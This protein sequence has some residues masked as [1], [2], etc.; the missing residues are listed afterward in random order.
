MNKHLAVVTIASLLALSTVGCSG[1]SGSSENTTAPA[2]NAN[3]DSGSNANSSTSSNADANASSNSNANAEATD[4]SSGNN[5]GSDNAAATGPT[6]DK[7]PKLD[8]PNLTLVYYMSPEQYAQT[9]KENPDYFDNTMETI[10]EFE[11]KYGGKVQVIAT[12]WGGMLEKTTAMQNAGTAPDLF[13]VSDQTFHNTVTKNIVQPVDDVTTDEDYAFWKV[14]KSVFAWKGK[15][16]AIPI[17]PY[18]KYILYNKTMFEDNG[19]KTPKEYYQEG[20]WNF[21]SFAEVGKE[22]TQDTT[23]S[24]K[25][26]QWG[27]STYQDFIPAIMVENGGSFLKVTDQ[28]V[29]SGLSDPATQEAMKYL[30]DWTKQPGG[31]INFS[32]NVYDAF[33]SGK[34]AM[35]VGPEYP[36]PSLSFDVD[37]VP[38]PVGPSNKDQ[39]EFVYPQGWS[40]P[41]GSKNPQGAAAFVYMLNQLTKDKGEKLELKRFGQENYDM[42]NDPDMKITYS[43]DKGLSNIWFLIGS[44]A[45]LMHDQVPPA[46]IAEKINPQIN[47][48]IEKVYGKQQ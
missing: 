11:K 41:T 17:K 21:D 37:M 43:I 32:L 2:A 42:I 7:Y 27:F 1:D 3:A 45:N 10:P 12:D 9:K 34:L 22:L 6:A 36:Q 48:A 4:D 39:S 44:V 14:G 5:A 46:T 47:A 31:F 40:V 16:Y 30:S 18:F 26:D 35:A 19:L 13:L 24:G 20:D 15:T 38:F 25:I 23:G 29:T 8:N 28:S 33:N